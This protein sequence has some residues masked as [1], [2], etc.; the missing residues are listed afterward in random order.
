MIPQSGAIGFLVWWSSNDD[1]HPWVMMNKLKFWKRVTLIFLVFLW[2]LIEHF[3]MLIYGFIQSLQGKSRRIWVELQLVF[4]WSS[5]QIW[6][7]YYS[8]SD[9]WT[10]TV[11][12][13]I[14][15]SN[16]KPSIKKTILLLWKVWDVWISHSI[17]RETLTLCDNMLFIHMVFCRRRRNHQIVVLVITY[18]RKYTHI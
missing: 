9:S 15:N 3:Y 18:I 5:N 2:W 12:T 13:G 1:F 16:I 6:R 17:P 14:K 7:S 8:D 10:L 4:N 11:S